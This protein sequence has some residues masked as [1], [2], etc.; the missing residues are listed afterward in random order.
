MEGPDAALERRVQ[1]NRGRCPLDG[2]GEARPTVPGCPEPPAGQARWTQRPLAGR[3]VELNIVE[4][5]SRPTVRKT[6][7]KTVSGPG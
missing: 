4:T 6:P 3:L 5:V 1:V 7:G 2:A